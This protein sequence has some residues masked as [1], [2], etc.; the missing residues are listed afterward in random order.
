MLG[1][2]PSLYCYR[3]L[4]KEHSK[5]PA[6]LPQG[7]EITGNHA[8][9]FQQKVFFHLSDAARHLVACRPRRHG[10]GRAPGQNRLG[11]SV[12]YK[13][14][15][16]ARRRRGARRTAGN[17]RYARAAGGNRSDEFRAAGAFRHLYAQAWSRDQR[18]RALSRPRR[19]IRFQADARNSR[20]YARRSR[21][22]AARCS[23]RRAPASGGIHRS[24]AAKP[25][26]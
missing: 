6:R 4:R 5:L 26:W 1:S 22:A 13:R 10:L 12:L 25:Y 18:Q 2:L 23:L 20:D 3:K 21:R 16:L 9:S 24:D 14:L 7:N 8:K 11:S 15:A 19:R 17:G